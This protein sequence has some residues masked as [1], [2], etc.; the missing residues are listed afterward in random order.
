YARAVAPEC[1][2]FQCREDLLERALPDLADAP[3]RE[4]VA[5]AVLA[6]QTGLFEQL[7]HL[8]QLL[9]R[10]T[11]AGTGEALDLIRIEG[12]EIVHRARATND[13]LHVGQLVH[14]VHET[15]RLR[16]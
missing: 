9:E 6:D 3:W 16:Q 8:L 1:V 12:I 5:L 7:D 14:L 13:L 15:E 11:R 2:T 10:L 4:L